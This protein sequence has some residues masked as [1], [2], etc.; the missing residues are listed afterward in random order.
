MLS[1]LKGFS[2]KAIIPH[3][4][5]P[6]CCLAFFVKKAKDSQIFICTNFNNPISNEERNLHINQQLLNNSFFKQ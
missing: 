3:E 6:G 1:D 5:W 4:I 2:E